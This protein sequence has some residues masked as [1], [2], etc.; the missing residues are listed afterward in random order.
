MA[1]HTLAVSG[2][3]HQ[4]RAILEELKVRAAQTYVPPSNLA[5]VHLG[6]GEHDEA[7]DRLEEAL[8]A[9]DLLLTFLAVE[10]RWADLDGNPRFTALLGRIGLK[11]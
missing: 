10:P 7:I 3:R 11:R 8:E 9:R 2:N 1:G 6:L 5:L 4:A